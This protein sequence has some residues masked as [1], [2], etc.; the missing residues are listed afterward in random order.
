MR[1]WYDI[2]PTDAASL[3]LPAPGIKGPL[4]EMGEPCPWPW[5][6]QQLAGAPM[7]QYHCTYCGGMVMAGM[8]H[9]DWRDDPDV[10]S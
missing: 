4:N 1:N 6:P 8:H 10:D 5:E 7:G 3:K 9:L 2:S